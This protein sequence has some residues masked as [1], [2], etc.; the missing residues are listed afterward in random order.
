M[1]SGVSEFVQA[2]QENNVDTDQQF[3]GQKQFPQSLAVL[4]IRL[5]LT[6]EALNILHKE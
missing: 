2:N 5:V 3:C 4:Q 6:P 1:V